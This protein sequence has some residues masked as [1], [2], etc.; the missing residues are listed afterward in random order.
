VDPT[1]RWRTLTT[2][3]VRVHVRAEQLALG[4]R[5]AVEAES[6]YAAL[7]RVLPSPRGRV[8]VVVAD[9]QDVANGYAT[10][11]PVARIVVFATPPAGDVLLGTYDRWLR[12]VLTHEMAHVF[13]VDLARGWWGVGRRVLGRA[14]FLFPNALTPDWVREGLA[15]HYETALTGAGRRDAGFHRA[16]VGAQAGEARPLPMDAATGLSPQWSGGLRPY[17]FGGTFLGAASGE[18]PDSVVARYALRTATEPIPWVR[19]SAAW[20]RES[21]QSLGQAWREWQGPL[22]TPAT[23]AEAAVLVRGLRSW[24]PPR[25]SPDGRHV[26]Y[27]H[28]DGRDEERLVS[29][30][31]GSGATRTL[32]RLQ[33]ARSIAATADGAVVVTQYDFTSRYELRSDLWSGREGRWRRVTVGARLSDADVGAD[34]RIV[35]VRSAGGEVALVTVSAAGAVREL[36]AAEA[37]VEWAAPRLSPDGRTVAAVRIARGRHDI[38]LLDRDGRITRA[39]SDDSA[40]DVAPAF[41]PDGRWL[42]WSREEP[43]AA[44]QIVGVS[45]DGDGT[46][47]QFTHEPW[48]A[49]APAPANDSLYYLG[50]HHDGLAL[51][52][53]PLV[54]EPVTVAQ[55]DAPAV[56]SVPDT[57]LRDSPYH[58][59]STLLPRYWL[60][61]LFTTSGGGAWWGVLTTG[62]DVLERWAY[63]VDAAFGSGAVAG[64]WRGSAALVHA[65]PGRLTLD[66]AYARDRVPVT[67]SAG[68]V[69]CCAVDDAAGAGLTAVRRRWRTALS[70]RVGGDWERSGT[71][72]RI[73]VSLR[74]AWSRG[75]TPPLA[76]SS[77]D[78]ARLGVVL[79]QRWRTDT[80]LTSTEL[81]GRAAGYLAWRTPGFARTVTAVRASAGALWGDDP[82]LFSV[83]GVAGG[84][85][86]LVPGVSIGGSARTFPVRGYPPEALLGR[87]VVSGSLEQR[88]PLALVSRGLGLLP[89][90]LD[91]VSV[92]AFADGATVWTPVDCAAETLCRQSLASFGGE[93]VADVG[94]GYDL[95]LRLRAGIAFPVLEGWRSP[96]T[97]VVAGASF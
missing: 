68:A 33:A 15:V 41:S 86:A 75:V 65:G 79:R 61:T 1:G 70:A 19:L 17:A 11:Y 18:H 58:A 90:G 26:L 60:P 56:A 82:V 24:T 39:L 40:L 34:G 51:S 97:Y 81:T 72:E 8:E 36:V 27:A 4:A 25:I 9:N 54:G 16:V 85:A 46:L 94:I 42:V 28:D 13:H 84:P 92:S 59:W 52:A 91:R 66:A 14:P 43:G 3:H 12:L 62:Q 69:T 77:Q 50:Y 57:V 30:E 71:R 80:D 37:G 95:P 6:A 5:A 2:P 7:A 76:I 96:E 22:A 53:V 78:A 93:L 31:R 38:L 74:A 44:P 64:A 23:A 89:L 32:G 67:D 73:G 63:A 49:W 55:D 47:R 21:G 83:G 88:M 45:L 10:P 20:R 35:A 29:L 87:R 48:A